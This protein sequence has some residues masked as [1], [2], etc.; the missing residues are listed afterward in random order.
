MPSHLPLKKVTLYKNSLGFFERCAPLSNGTETNEDQRQFTLHVV[1]VA[2]RGLL[3]RRPAYCDRRVFLRQP[4]DRKGMV[5]DTLSCSAGDANNAVVVKHDSEAAELADAAQD[6]ES[7]GFQLGSIA[8]FLHSVVGSEV[9]VSQTQNTTLVTG[10]V[11]MLEKETVCI[12]GSEGQCES[13][14]RWLY[15]IDSAGSIAK[16]TLADI[17]SLSMRDPYL[18]EQLILTLTKRIEARKPVKKATGK[19]AITLSAPEGAGEMEVGYV[20]RTE[21]WRA[22]YRLQMPA[23]EPHGQQQQQ[24]QVDLQVLG[25]VKNTTQEDWENVKLSLVANEIKM[26]YKEQARGGA[27]STS[28]SRTSYGGGSMQ[29]FIKTLTGTKTSLESMYMSIWSI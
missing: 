5:V 4:L 19:T 27:G 23:D 29:L 13:L 15:I 11:L 25:L 6:E 2:V 3:V 16:V 28:R 20:D 14:W 8:D 12:P 10:K 18:Q 24:Q 7:F 17:A 21:E 9:S 1:T 26:T 22:S